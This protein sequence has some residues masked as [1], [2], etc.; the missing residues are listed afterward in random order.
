MYK[1]EQNNPSNDFMRAWNAAGRHIQL[2]ADTGFSWLRDKLY[3]PMAEHL[4]FRIG[5]QI[6]FVYVEGSGIKSP[7]N[8]RIFAKVCRD[9][10]AIPCLMEMRSRSGKWE[11]ENSGWGLTHAQTGKNLNP[12][13]YVSDELIEMTDWELHDFAIQVVCEEL[14]KTGRTILSKQPSRDIEPSIWFEDLL[15]HQF[16]VIRAERHPETT[17]DTP[18]NIEEIKLSCSGISDIGYFVRV[19]FVSSDDPLDPDA[20]NNG[21]F[22]PLYRGHGVHP[23]WSGLQRIIVAEDEES[24]NDKELVFQ[25]WS[26]FEGVFFRKI[27]YLELQT[28]HKA[29]YQSKTWREFSERLPGGEF[30]SLSMWVENDGEYIYGVD[31]DLKFIESREYPDFMRD[32]GAD[33]IIRA[34]DPFDSSS[35]PGAQDGDYPGW[36]YRIADECLPE[37]FKNKY[38][39]RVSS[40]VSGS[41]WEFPKEQLDEMTQYLEIRGFTVSAVLSLD[42]DVEVE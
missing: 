6:F 28:V 41:W 36:T 1:V 5:N 42:F 25:L 10:N 18:A 39:E 11:P 19:I 35:V 8:K 7:S 2:Q 13:D 21:N 34:D 32:Y 17:V 12:L 31:G 3:T 14:E 40:M 37:E 22:L 38:G 27:D 30:E 26:D 29:L 15:G 16:V 20:K 4:S 23:N 24:N 33:Y 9:A